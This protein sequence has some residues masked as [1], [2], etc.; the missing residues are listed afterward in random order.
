MLE[1]NLGINVI[2]TREADV[3][4]PLWKR[5]KLANSAGGKLF[6]SLHVNSTST[7]PNIKG[8]ETYLLR[9]GKTNQAIEVVKREN[10]VIEL[11][12]ENYQYADLKNENYIIASMAQNSFMK[13]SEDLAALI[14]QYM[15]QNLQ[16]STKN[17]GVKQAGFHVLVGATMPNVLVEVGF[18]SNKKEALPIAASR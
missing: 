16:G 11:E 18:L 3:F 7:S 6:I 8:Y 13:E 1:R 2:Y 10:S 17:R 4:V 12:K 14:Q 5:T 15:E 9:P